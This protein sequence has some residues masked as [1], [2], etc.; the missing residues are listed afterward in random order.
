MNQKV[1]AAQR[2]WD[3]LQFFLCLGIVGLLLV[4]LTVWHGHSGQG[5]DAP[6]VIEQEFDVRVS[7]PKSVAIRPDSPIFHKLQVVTVKETETT[8]PIVTVT[9]VDVASLQT[10]GQT[11]GGG[12]PD[13]AISLDQL[14]DFWQFHSAELL[15]AFADWQKAGDDIAFAE[16]QLQAVEKLVETTI[17][18]QKL[19]VERLERLVQVGTEAIVHVGDTDYVL[20]R[21]SSTDWTAAEVQIGELHEAGVEVYSGL[22]NGDQIVGKGVIL[23]KPV[24]AEALRLR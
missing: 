23:L 7:G 2:A 13:S 4:Y 17:E 14:N 8:D 9:G 22:E 20:V 10:N 18:A 21:K 12:T 15:T 19:A 3:T 11:N 6:E 24:I 1:S 5:H 16:K